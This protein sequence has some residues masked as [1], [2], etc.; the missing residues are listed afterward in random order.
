MI[1]AGQGYTQVPLTAFLGLYTEASPESLPEGASP[2]TW[3]TDFVIGGVKM[4]PGK[5]SAFAFSGS[6]TGPNGCQSGTAPLT[7]LSPWTNPGAITAH[8]AS[9][10]SATPSATQT[11]P[12]VIAGMG[13]NG[14]LLGPLWSNPNDVTSGASYATLTSGSGGPSSALVASGFLFSLPAS[15]AVD[16][17]IV[18]FQAF[19]NS[20]SFTNLVIVQLTQ[21]GNPVGNTKTINLSST[22]PATYTL[23]GSGDSW[24]ATLSTSDTIG[25]QFIAQNGVG[26]GTR[27]YSL[28]NVQMQ[29]SYS[30][31]ISD[32]LYAKTFGFSLPSQNLTGFQIGVTGYVT[33]TGVLTAQLLQA[34]VPV[35]TVKTFALTSSPTRVVLGS[36]TD[37]WGTTLA[38]SDVNGTNFGVV[39]QAI[40]TFTAYIDYVDCTVS[41]TSGRQNFNWFGTYERESISQIDTLALD[42]L[43]TL[44]DENVT[45]DQGILTSIF[46]GI[47][48]NSFANGSTLDAVEYLAISDLTAGNDI[49]RQWDG[50]TLNRVS[51]VG[52]GAAPA[53]SF[54]STTY[55]EAA[56]PNGI[57]QPAAVVNTGSGV[58]IRALLWSSGPGVKHTPGN[59]ITIY[60]GIGPTTPDPD[61]QVG[62]GVVLA[63]FASVGGVSPNLTY[64]ITG[65]GVQPAG[66]F[67][68]PINYFTVTATSTENAFVTP[69]TSSSY[70]SSLATVTTTVPVPGVQV[71]TSI[72]LAGN[73]NATWNQTWT[74]LFTP[75]GAQLLITSTSLAANVATYDYVLV[76]GTDPSAGELV[77]IT[78]TA[79]G[80]G[81][82]NIVDGVV[83]SATSSSF[84]VNL[85]G[86]NVTSSAESGNGIINGTE[87]QIDPAPL[88]AGTATTAI[89]G[90]DGG[91][92]LSIAGFLGAGTRQA[93]VM[94]LTDSDYLTQPSPFATFTL[95]DDASSI[96]A[97]LIPI[98]PPNTKARWI[99]FTG[100]QGGYYYVIPEPVSVVSNGQTIT[101]TSTVINDNTTTSATFTFTDAVLLAAD[102]IDVQGNDNFNQMELGP[103]LGCIPYAGRMFYWGTLDK[104]TNFNNLTFDGGYLPT[105]QTSAVYPLG[106][107][108]DQVNGRGGN[109]Q[110]SPVFGNSYLISNSFGGT[111]ATLGLITQGAFQ[112]Q[113]NV[114][115]IEP[116]TTYSV[117]IAA[118]TPSG[119][120]AGVLTI[121]LYSPS[122]NLVYGTASFPTS[123]MTTTMGLYSTTLLTNDFTGQIPSDLQ[124]RMYFKNS[125]NGEN[126]EVD[127]IEVFPTEEPVLET[128]VIGSYEA[129]FEAFDQVTGPIDTSLINQQSVRS[130]FTLFDDLY[131]L[132]TE[133]LISTQD[134]QTSEPEGWTLR[135]VSNIVGTPSVNGVDSG[136]DWAVIASRKGPYGFNGGEPVPLGPEIRSLWN[137]INWTYGNTLW[138]SNDTVNRRIVFGVPLATPNQW[139]PLAPVNAN[140]TTPNV[141]LALNYVDVNGISELIDEAVRSSA[142]T[143]KLLA[144]DKSRKWTIWNIQAPYG[145]LITR[146]DGTTPM[147][148]GNSMGTGKAYQLIEGSTNDDGLAINELYTTYGWVTPE[149]GQALQMGVVR[150]G[151]YLLRGVIDGSGALSVKAIPEKLSSPYA[152]TLN[153]TLP[154]YGD[155][156]MPLNQTASRL[157]TQFSTNAVGDNFNLSQLVMAMRSDP[158]IPVRGS[159]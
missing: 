5:Q 46:T 129:N 38:Y 156:E 95:P 68:Q 135:T 158:T 103:S 25:V 75:N 70:Q 71:G 54:S 107:T 74:V 122:F 33:G 53:F 66:L 57:T 24:G 85:V 89:L 60:Y 102:E 76:S 157:Y 52:P 80:G 30:G 117:R 73:S 90:N 47:A 59:V 26:G 77:T 39:L 34:G 106:W 18:S 81:I 155:L 22:S 127:R 64:I 42:A 138:V 130:C 78:N 92:T 104:I 152:S 147:F 118:R 105:S 6:S 83:V 148:L 98:G 140:P 93:V 56:S 8:D 29:L 4:R 3:D 51:Q 32:P 9:Y 27:I 35:G 149:T 48:P 159:N 88:Y 10:A 100:A 96:F 141:C 109:L 58:P 61:L 50:T 139:L 91:G 134:N 125:A 113:Y 19:I 20:V 145:A 1:N 112:D 84:T 121:D 43:G 110:L 44:W 94:F 144:R 101:Y 126:V 97:T 14:P 49:P 131:I 114:A 116:L 142:F 37:I 146:Q 12:L 151:Y 65:I 99:A 133:S 72:S 154:T 36:P 67:A 115:I 23:G 119:A 15:E 62:L 2:L 41:Q 132:K 128:D 136:E 153:L 17:V 86:A 21:N 40:G 79:N 120:T 143:G 111:V 7:G 108:I 13:A 150:H 11:T 31:D 69:A 82:F 16:G 28:N 87:F 137:M 63:N 123:G 45:S 124:L 55:P